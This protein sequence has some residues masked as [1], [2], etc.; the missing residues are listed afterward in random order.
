MQGVWLTLGLL[1]SI[2]PAL[3]ADSSR[4]S[5]VGGN[6]QTTT[7]TKTTT[8]ASPCPDWSAQ[9]YTVTGSGGAVWWATGTGTTY[10]R[11]E[12]YD[13]R[14]H[15]QGGTTSYHTYIDKFN[16]QLNL[17]REQRSGSWSLGY[18]CIRKRDS[19][20]F[21]QIQYTSSEA[22]GECSP[23]A[24]GWKEVGGRH[25][26]WEGR[27]GGTPRPQ[28]RVEADCRPSA[29][30]N[31][32]P[33]SFS[34]TGL[35]YL[36]DGCYELQ[37]GCTS[38]M[39]P[40]YSRTQNRS[41]QYLLYPTEDSSN[42]ALGF[43]EGGVEDVRTQYTSYGILASGWHTWWPKVPTHDR[44]VDLP[45]ASIAKPDISRIEAGCPRLAD[46]DTSDNNSRKVFGFSILSALSLAFFLALFC[47]AGLAWLVK[48]IPTF[49]VLGHSLLTWR[50]QHPSPP[51][52]SFRSELYPRE[53]VVSMEETCSTT[54]TSPPSTLSEALPRYM[55]AINMAG[56]SQE[57][58]QTEELPSYSEAI[59]M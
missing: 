58:S 50:P 20:E 33:T 5:H 32:F 1:A 14:Y 11:L 25:W 44:E 38:W 16:K 18:T 39:S 37:A 52:T 45:V 54:A 15:L 53:L 24:T 59:N 19:V 56:G 49:L 17:F 13:G 48:K 28:L 10:K 47:V 7:T 41:Y 30:D 21:S 2:N 22:V 12:G 31:I 26:G 3:P 6:T 51:N 46:N 40:Y 36:Y 55:E 57:E 8:T 43:T 9:S 29:T 23:P 42:W 4:T 27:E 34:V 35:G